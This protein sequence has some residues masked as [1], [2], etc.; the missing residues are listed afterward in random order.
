MMKNRFMAFCVS[1]AMLAALP[2]AVKQA[3]IDADAANRQL[4]LIITYGTSMT[5]Q[6]GVPNAFYARYESV[7]AKVRNKYMY[8]FGISLN[9]TQPVQNFVVEGPGDS[10]RRGTNNFDALC[11]HASNYACS[12]DGPYHHTNCYYIRNVVFPRPRP[13]VN[14]VEVYMVSHRICN[15][16]DD[17][18][19]QGNIL[20][21]TY[22]GI[23]TMVVRDYDYV[24][25][26]NVTNWQ[27]D[28]TNINYVSKTLAHEIGH[29]YN[30]DDH[31]DTQFGTVK[32]D[33][34][35]GYNKGDDIVVKGLLMCSDCK[36]V[37]MNNRD[38]YNMS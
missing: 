18:T 29:L 2:G 5:M 23:M 1:L 16:A 8:N 6:Y 12:N 24:E 30:V 3:E 27:G 22:P 13:Y 21:M 20:A 28:T 37:I 31:Y 35:W 17:G 19:H 34:I 14:G 4:N 32:D 25:V 15:V 11:Q 38:W 33:C 7:T 9:F 26:D 10:C 36:N